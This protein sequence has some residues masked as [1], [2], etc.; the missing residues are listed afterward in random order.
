MLVCAW[1]CVC[2][3]VCECV[4]V[5]VCV[6]ALD[7]CLRACAV[8]LFP[9]G[10]FQGFSINLALVGPWVIDRLC[11]PEEGISILGSVP[12]SEVIPTML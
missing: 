8:A 7:A 10:N 5:R 9:C 6:R 12:G 3:C 4:R 1:V 11:S 2:V